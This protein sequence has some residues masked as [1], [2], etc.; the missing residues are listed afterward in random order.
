MDQDHVGFKEEDGFIQNL[1]MDIMYILNNAMFGMEIDMFI[2]KEVIGMYGT[3][4]TTVILV[5]E[6]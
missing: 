5:L 2:T 6:E 1:L 3:I 4:L